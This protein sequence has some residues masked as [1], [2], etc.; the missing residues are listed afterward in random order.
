[1]R[2]RF[3]SAVAVALSISVI[4]IGSSIASPPPAPPAPVAV[5]PAPLALPPAPGAQNNPGSQPAAPS[6]AASNA[7]PFNPLNGAPAATPTAQA[8]P[9]NNT[10]TFDP[11]SSV[12]PT[13]APPAPTDGVTTS[14]T[15]TTTT[16]STN[17]VPLAIPNTPL[18]I[19]PPEIAPTGNSAVTNKANPSATPF[20][21]LDGNVPPAP[22]DM[23]MPT[24]T[25]AQAAAPVDA[26]KP[27]PKFKPSLAAGKKA[28]DKSQYD[29]ARR[30]LLPLARKG[31]TEAQYLMGVIYSHAKGNLR[32]YQKAAY[33]YDKAAEKGVK[34]A[35]FNLGFMLYQGAGESGSSSSVAQDYAQSAKYLKLAADQ[36][37][38]M[39]QHLLSLLHMRGQGVQANMY[40]A[41]RYASS[42]ADN[43][44]QESMFNAGMISVRRPGATMQDYINAYKWFTILSWQGYPGA[45]ENR[46][47]I[48]KY[49]PVNAIQYAES[50]ARSWRPPEGSAGMTMPGLSP[51]TS[52]ESPMA[53]PPIAAQ[54]NTFQNNAWY[55]SPAVSAPAM[56]VPQMQPVQN[57]SMTA[58]DTYNRN[59]TMGMQPSRVQP[60]TGQ[61]MW[62]GDVGYTAPATPTVSPMMMQPAPA[63]TM[64]APS[65]WNMGMDKVPYHQMGQ[66]QMAQPM[67]NPN[68]WPWPQES[69]K[70]DQQPNAY[71]PQINQRERYMLTN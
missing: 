26:P 19:P 7:D 54:P 47:L 38:P 69:S 53:I 14:T 55:G 48:T 71:T 15:T 31:N 56:N 30:H 61:S 57:H 46:A 58:N 65:G 45:A 25:M 51:S 34:E 6:T 22:T 17:T 4:L 33:W 28:F 18:N 1:M 49:M 41:L 29:T 42:A 2:N 62:G 64:Q 8:S 39:A 35:Q 44:V 68:S 37:V 16:T 36:G 12:T 27:K 24:D 70:S 63:P 32:D 10:G 66:P 20:G 21:S 9:N 11:F 13:A 59:N 3:L 60:M 23:A 5:D 50:Q 43:G 52:M 67:A 40:E